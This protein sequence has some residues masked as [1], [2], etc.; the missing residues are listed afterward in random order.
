[1][2]LQSVK[3]A[4]AAALIAATGVSAYAVPAMPG[5]RQW[6]Q[7]DG[8][9]IAVQVAGDE[10]LAIYTTDDNHFL[11][12]RDGNFYY[13]QPSAD[14]LSLVPSKYRAVP[15]AERSKEVTRFLNSLD[16]VEM[17]QAA[18][19][20]FSGRRQAATMAAAAMAPMAKAGPG[21]FNDRGNNF[22]SSGDRKVLVILMQ[23]A[24]RKFG[25]EDPKAYF[26]RQLNEDGFSDNGGTGSAAEYFRA[27]SFDQFRPQFDVYGPY[28]STYGYK[29]YGGETSTS[30][31]SNVRALVL[32]AIA[33]ATAEGDMSQY[34]TD[35]DGK[36]D[37]ICVIYAGVG[38][39]SSTDVDAIWPH[40]S[41]VSSTQKYDGKTAYRYLVTNEALAN[42]KPAGIGTL[43]HEFSHVMGLPDLY[44]T[45]Y[46]GTAFLPG[47]WDV[48]SSASYLNNG[49]TPC[50]YSAQERYAMGWIEPVEITG[51]MKG[52]LYPSGQ[53]DIVYKISTNRA[54]EYYL[55]ENR[56]RTG[57]DRY[58]PG[59][60]ML[61]WHIHFVQSIW[62]ENCPCNYPNHQYVDI[63]EAD[64]ILTEGTRDGDTF[65]G[66]S[67]ITSWT[68]DTTP[69]MKT[70]QNL[71]LNLPI[72]DITETAPYG[73]V[74]FN[75]AGGNNSLPAVALNAATD[76]TPRSFKASWSKSSAADAEYLL[77]VYTKVNGAEVYAPGYD[78]RNVR[79]NTSFEVTGLEPSTQY[80]YSVTVVTPDA[81]SPASAEAS[82]T[83]GALT[84]GYVIP[85][86]SDASAIH[87]N[88][89]TA[90]WQAIDGGADSYELNVYQHNLQGSQTVTEGF[91][92]SGSD[93]YATGTSFSTSVSYSGD[94]APSLQL[95]PDQY[96]CTPYI[97]QPIRKFSFKHRGR[98]NSKSA[99]VVVEAF[100]GECWVPFATASVATTRMIELAYYNIPADAEA[101]RVL[102]A[103]TKGELYVDDLTVEYGGQTNRTLVAQRNTS[104][105]SAL[106]EGVH[107]GTEHYYNLT[108]IKG[109]ERSMVSN[110]IRVRTTG[111]TGIDTVGTD[112]ASSALSVN[113]TDGTLSITAP[114]GGRITVTDLSGRTVYTGYGSATLNVASG[115]YIVSLNGTDAVKVMVR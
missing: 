32:E 95:D 56:Q 62:N 64:N 18:A 42:G 70:W 44:D 50:L 57:W 101:L 16:A 12:L 77:S 71:S 4:M 68:D 109:G 26:T 1:M 113:G 114:E 105:L 9:T 7:A 102:Y 86:A 37:N 100:I 96:V 38:Q 92:G 54:A 29:Y 85:V 63:V 53:S 33:K 81:S 55:L 97:D 3:A 61:V 82:A 8:Q 19:M 84:H 72:T 28:T 78:G 93:W 17:Q 59:H 20:E 15:T 36:I 11:T 107:S 31:D 24:D 60:G 34:D 40:S 35:G 21:L 90:N 73:I 106:I 89:F 46:G 110:D 48:M 75:V 2:K 99:R 49:N 25:L 103:D 91:D 6:R 108:A 13:A 76:V 39:A 104:A 87:Q 58:I 67:G 74:T 65:P 45:G 30:N 10:H 66:A 14:G 27:S 80:Y 79:R 23:Y 69:S 43:C 83:T 52:Q 5:V 112:S 47:D 41:T 98:N 22:P 115:L 51:S 111:S 88:D 94:S